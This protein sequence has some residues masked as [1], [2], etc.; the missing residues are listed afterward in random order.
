MIDKNKYRAERKEREILDT[1]FALS[2]LLA[3]LNELNPIAAGNT[4]KGVIQYLQEKNETKQLFT[5]KELTDF[6][7]LPA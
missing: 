4:F 5:I 6:G 2:K 1:A 7:Y 3:E